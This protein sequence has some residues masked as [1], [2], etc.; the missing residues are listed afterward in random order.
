MKV[1]QKAPR[2]QRKSYGK[3]KQTQ[4]RADPIIVRRALGFP[5][6]VQ[7]P[8]SKKTKRQRRYFTR[9]AQR[10]ASSR[11]PDRDMLN[12][13]TRL[14]LTGSGSQP[15]GSQVLIGQPADISQSIR[16]QQL[17]KSVPNFHYPCLYVTDRLG[18]IFPVDGGFFWYDTEPVESWN[19][20]K[21]KSNELIWIPFDQE[22]QPMGFMFTPSLKHTCTTGYR[23]TLQETFNMSTLQVNPSVEFVFSQ[24]F[25]PNSPFWY[26]WFDQVEVYKPDPP[27]HIGFIG[28][29]WK[30]E[31]LGLSRGFLV[32]FEIEYQFPEC[33]LFHLIDFT[34]DE[35]DLD[36]TTMVG[37]SF[38]RPGWVMSYEWFL[39]N[40]FT[41]TTVRWSV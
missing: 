23:P 34:A 24:A 8:S 1:V 19:S 20:R 11:G 15:G 32:H 30:W 6:D 37:M 25:N 38:Y 14:A 13:A 21:L 29:S 22:R 41:P 35:L 10:F 18:H 31:G 40:P 33:I 12:K 28:R 2:D 36:T 7:H 16:N 4:G 3:Y 27:A 26:P 17:G 9:A 39:I 5:G